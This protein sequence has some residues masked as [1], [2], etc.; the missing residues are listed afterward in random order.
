[1]NNPKYEVS[2]EMFDPSFFLCKERKKRIEPCEQEEQG[3]TY[4]IDVLPEVLRSF[5]E[6]FFQ[7]NCV[8]YQNRV[9]SIFLTAHS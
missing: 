2:S 5:R 6:K 9:L 3:S 8:R 1:M 7:R 4:N